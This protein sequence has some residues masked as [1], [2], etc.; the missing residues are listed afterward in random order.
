MKRI[1][2]LGHYQKGV[3]LLMLVMVLVFT[4]LYPLVITLEGFEYM[5]AILVSS[6]ENGSTVY[7]GKIQGKRAAFTV[8]KDKTV[9]FQYGDTTYGPY[10][11]IEDAS[12]IPEDCV[13]R[14]GMTGVELRCG[15]KILF[16]G[17]VSKQGDDFWLYDEHGD[18]ENF[19]IAGIIDSENFIIGS[20]ENTAA[21]MDPSVATVLTLM[22]G[23]KLT[24]KGNWL[25]WLGGV[26]ICIITAVSILFADKL[27]RW[28]LSFLIQHAER[29]EPSDWEI[30]RRYIVWTL[31][32]FLAML[33]FI[34]GLL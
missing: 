31:F 7:A 1:K 32:P 2:S 18:M 28:N 8:Q 12:A 20:R 9:Y 13:T 3:L 25:L 6:H 11:A 21:R 19:Y 4:V 27:F 15:E 14:E 22:A 26:S 23:P 5:D 29:A 30:T 34:N 16:R 17:G 24:H 33:L 10:T